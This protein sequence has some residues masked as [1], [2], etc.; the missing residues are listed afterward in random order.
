L[1]L[2]KP[3][4]HFLPTGAVTTPTIQVL[5]V[6]LILKRRIILPTMQIQRHDI[7]RKP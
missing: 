1:R 7:G 2:I 3:H 4:S 5:L 6:I